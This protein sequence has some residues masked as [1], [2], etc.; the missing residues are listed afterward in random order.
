[1]PRQSERVKAINSLQT[2]I[3]NRKEEEYMNFLFDDEDSIEQD[4]TL[5][6]E[7]QL[8]TIKSKRYC[9]RQSNY[10][11]MNKKNFDWND[12]IAED[13]TTFTAVEFLFLFRVNR[14]T[15][16]KLH[17]KIKNSTH[18]QP[19][20]NTKKKEEPHGKCF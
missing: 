8:E 2:L 14:E 5:E 10:C 15:F 6:L 13:S 11:P 4:Y 17:E 7:T 1:M 12:I 16:W 9:F 20:P 18:F 19:K 3:D